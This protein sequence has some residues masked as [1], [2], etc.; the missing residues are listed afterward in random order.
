MLNIKIKELKMP[1]KNDPNISHKVEWLCSSLGI[2]SNR[3][4]DNTSAKILELLLNNAKRSEPLTSDDIAISLNIARS[5]ALHHL[6]K[7]EASG[8]IIKDKGYSLK[9]SSIEEILDE[10]ELDIKRTLERM[11]KIAKEIDESLGL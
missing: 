8:I 6:E 7:Y 1:N 2:L 4:K 11:R 5:T 9:A 10:L 3:D